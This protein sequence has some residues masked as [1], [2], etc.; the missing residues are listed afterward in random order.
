MIPASREQEWRYEIWDRT[1]GYTGRNLTGVEGGF[2]EWHRNQAIKG[3]G[4]LNVVQS[5]SDETLLGVYIRPVL[6]IKDWGEQP[7]GLWVPSF[8]KRSFTSTGW[9]GT[10]GLVSLEAILSYTSAASLLNNS[11]T[12]ITVSMTTGTNVTNWVTDLIA[13]AGLTRYAITSS[14]QTQ[15][16]PKSWT[17]G[18]SGLQVANDALTSIG[19]TSL[20]SDMYGTIRADQYL[21]PADRP[22]SFSTL[23]PFDTLDGNSRLRTSFDIIDNSPNTPNRVRAIGARVGWLPGQTAVSIND[24]PTSPYSITNRGY[25]VEKVYRDVD[26]LSQAAV[27]AYAHQQLLNLSK[28]G[29]KAEVSF[30]HIPG[31]A[32]NQ[33]VYFNVPRA[34]AP[35]FATVD[36]LKVDL[37]PEGVSDATLTAVTAVED[38]PVT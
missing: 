6:T 13:A 11:L 15:T 7:F 18:E 35:M 31:L 8:P 23:R 26:A 12:Q 25:V 1:T 10:V 21:L 4:S 2:L 9:S 16:S 22:E 37:A 5:T 20:Y 34:G 29:R 38:E 3:Q 14:T 28:D 24:D 36:R 17:E 27:Q 30:L 33:V 19:Y 32:I